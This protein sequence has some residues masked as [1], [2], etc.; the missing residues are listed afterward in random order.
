MKYPLLIVLFIAL[1]SCVREEV[2]SSAKAVTICNKEQD[3]CPDEEK[4]PLIDDDT[5]GNKVIPDE[6]K[7]E[8]D[9][10]FGHYKKELDDGTYEH[11]V[12][13]VS[14]F[15]NGRPD[16]MHMKIMGSADFNARK[17]H[18]REYKFYLHGVEEPGVR[19]QTYYYGETEDGV[20][21]KWYPTGTTSRLSS[22]TANLEIQKPNEDRVTYLIAGT[23]SAE[24]FQNFFPSNELSP[25]PIP[26]GLP[27]I[28]DQ[29]KD[30][31]DIRTLCHRLTPV[32][33][34]I[35]VP[36][37]PKGYVYEYT[38]RIYY[39]DNSISKRPCKIVFTPSA[40]RYLKER[41][42]VCSLDDRDYKLNL[43]LGENE[44]FGFYG[45]IDYTTYYVLNG[46]TDGTLNIAEYGDID[47]RLGSRRA[48]FD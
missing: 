28:D 45:N 39:D 1:S 18:V 26:T 9:Y 47:S 7:T 14:S 42:V 11:V 21:I 12:V 4:A 33:E 27:D 48:I 23:P 3:P 6:P 10:Y 34:V 38:A 2:V 30:R 46:R 29:E 36:G 15:P 17:P 5:G 41:G 13:R 25:L 20:I 16:I 37:I 32:S 19:G 31:E 24:I 43:Q 8:E 40:I 35:D 22:W 44:S